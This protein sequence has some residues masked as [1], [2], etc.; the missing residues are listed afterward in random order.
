MFFWCLAF[1]HSQI[2]TGKILEQ[3]VENMQ[4][5]VSGALRENF[6]LLLLLGFGLNF[7]NPF[8]CVAI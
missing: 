6:T 8:V 4:G 7:L 5:R 1:M 2:L 3:W